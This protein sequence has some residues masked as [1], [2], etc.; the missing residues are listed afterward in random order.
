MYFRS[1]QP[2]ADG[3]RTQPLE[4]GNIKY[5]EMVVTKVVYALSFQY[6]QKYFRM[7]PLYLAAFFG[8]CYDHWALKERPGWLLMRDSADE[9]S[10]S[11]DGRS[12]AGFGEP[13]PPPKGLAGATPKGKKAKKPVKPKWD[14]LNRIVGMLPPSGHVDRNMDAANNGETTKTRQ[15]GVKARSG[16]QGRETRL[17]QAHDLVRVRPLQV[18]QYRAHVAGPLEACTRPEGRQRN[19]PEHARE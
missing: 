13:Q 2:F 14:P 6:V 12:A 8:A 3:D 9:H 5:D 17:D 10:E 15:I 4:D 7:M 11:L 18:A 16:H 19:A 1:Y